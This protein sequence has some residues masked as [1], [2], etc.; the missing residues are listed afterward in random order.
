MHRRAGVLLKKL[1]HAKQGLLRRI[2]AA[3][4]VQRDV[5]A[6]AKILSRS[7]AAPVGRAQGINDGKDKKRIG[8]AAECFRSFRIQHCLS[9]RLVGAG[10]FVNYDATAVH[11]LSFRPMCAVAQ[12]AFAGELIGGKRFGSC[13][14]MRAA[15]GRALLRMAALRIWH[16]S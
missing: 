13:L 8:S 3:H 7:L 4:Y 14:V 5:H 9:R 10:A 16:I 11:E 2:V 1:M 12:V 15:L 6:G